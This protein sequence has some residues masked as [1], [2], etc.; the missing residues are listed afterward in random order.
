MVKRGS[1]GRGVHQQTLTRLLERGTDEHY[2]DPLLYDFEYVDQYDDI[3]WYC[4][5]AQARVRG[6]KLLELGAGSGRVSI[7]LAEDGHRVLALDRM[8]A[9]LEHLETKLERLAQAGE[10]LAGSI[11][12]VPGDMGA[13]PLP[14]ASVSMV[15]APFNCLMHLYTWQ[16]L[17]SCFRQVHRVLEPGGSFAFDVLL[18]DLEWLQWDPDLRHAVTEFEHPRTGKR[19]LY[20][21]NHSYDPATQ[22]CHIRIFYDDCDAHPRGR[23]SPDVAPLDT[24]HLA[25]RQIFPE[26]L[27]MLVST[28]GF[29]IESH[30]GDFLGLSLSSKVEVQT[31][32][33]VK[34]GGALA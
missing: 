14:D 3:E 12:L 27:R 19:M 24:V 26:E 7:P 34:P 8:P 5:Q 29:E 20:S 28:A 1:A 15:I 13:L 4:E 33:C 10:G 6:G 21:T 32:I 31:M 11:E 18:P 16:E 30:A 22:V 2:R 25:H 23:L 17:L 9:M